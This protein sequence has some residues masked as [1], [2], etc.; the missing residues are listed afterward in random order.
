MPNE[1]LYGKSLAQ[2]LQENLASRGYD[3]PFI[4]CEDWGWWVSLAAPFDF[5]VCIYAAPNDG[6]DPEE[7]VCTDSTGGRRAW[8]WRKFR[9]ID[10]A[11][12]SKKLDQD[13]I[14][15]FTADEEVQV[16]GVTEEFPF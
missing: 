12:W 14:A 5:G 3:V 16:V 6:K 8:S 13:L 2:Y 7:F 10:T 9:F 11:P 15:I 1:G 4:C